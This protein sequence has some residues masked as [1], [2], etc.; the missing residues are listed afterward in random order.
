VDPGAT[1]WECLEEALGDEPENRTLFAQ[2]FRDSVC[3]GV[4]H[5]VLFGDGFDDGALY[6]NSAVRCFRARGIRVSTFCIGGDFTARSRYRFL[7]AGTG[8]LYLALPAGRS[9]DDAV[10]DPVL[11]SV[12]PIV[13][14]FACGDHTSLAALPAL[15]PEARALM[16]Q[17]RT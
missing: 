1:E 13:A 14:A 2:A 10:L 7:A 17:V 16:K 15:T 5:V 12:L 6:L 11:N 8:G 3:H 4:N 9:L